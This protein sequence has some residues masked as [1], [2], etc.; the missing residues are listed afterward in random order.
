MVVGKGILLLATLLL[1]A[2]GAGGG[3]GAPGAGTNA[4]AIPTTVQVASTF[5]G[6]KTL[7]G[8]FTYYRDGSVNTAS[9]NIYARDINNDGVDE[10]LKDSPVRR[11]RGE[12]CGRRW[13]LHQLAL[14]AELPLLLPLIL[15]LNSTKTE[16]QV[17]RVR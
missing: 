7:A 8:V 14:S 13:L 17:R 10:V 2:C 1:S 9:S 5:L 15:P 12:V 6:A 4:S 11:G 16:R 3:G